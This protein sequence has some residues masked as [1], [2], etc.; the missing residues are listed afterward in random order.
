ML[1]SL[2]MHYLTV[3]KVVRTNQLQQYNAAFDINASE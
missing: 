2:K 3:Y 1:D